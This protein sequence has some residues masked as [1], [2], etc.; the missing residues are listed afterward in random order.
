MSDIP[1]KYKIF[2][3]FALAF[4]SLG[5]L[6]QESFIAIINLWVSKDNPT[7]SHG[8]LL[9]LISIFIIY[10]QFSKVIPG[11]HFYPSYIGLLLLFLASLIW[12][13]GITGFVQVVHMLLL[14]V[15]ICLVFISILGWRQSLPFLFPILLLVCALPVWDIVSPYLQHFTAITAGWLTT[16]TIRPSVRDG[17]LI[18]IPAGTF[19]VDTGCSGL[20]YFIV[21]I[22]VALLYSY[23][24]KLSFGRTLFHVVMAMIIAIVANIIRVYIIILSGQL[25][26][27]KGYL[28]TVEHA[29]LGWAIFLVVMTGYLWLASRGKP[30]N[31]PWNMDIFQYNSITRKSVGNTKYWQF[32][33]I[34]LSIIVFA[35]LFNLAYLN[36]SSSAEAFA[37][38]FPQTS[39]IWHLVE[40]NDR[41]EPQLIKGDQYIEASYESMED[42]ERVDIFLNHF[43]KQYQGVE[44][45]SDM[46]K[47]YAKGEW[48]EES[49]KIIVPEINGFNNLRE[50]ILIAGNGDYRLVWSWYEANNIRTGYAWEA[51]YQNILGRLLG[52]PTIRMLVLSTDI[53]D[54][55]INSRSRLI[56]LYSTVI[57]PYNQSPK[58][59]EDNG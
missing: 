46:N 48:L 5:I 30:E 40:K 4:I 17:L 53:S 37:V 9:L 7:Y 50:T 26:N 19:E 15:I 3:I 51:K 29:S 36:T 35:P 57:G 2:L 16:L 20:A 43:R 8:P 21:S 11:L 12:V 34:L 25:T 42:G 52:D 31:K 33:V 56:N 54:N 13:M 18:L 28:I 58:N 24:S 45:V 14:V 44:A 6:Y 22:V 1:E 55:I 59:T 23:A 38:K 32:V 47:L 49:S 41:Y 10:K 27:M 39:G